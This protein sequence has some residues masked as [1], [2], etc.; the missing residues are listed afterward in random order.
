[1]LKN[2]CSLIQKCRDLTTDRSVTAVI[3]IQEDS[4]TRDEF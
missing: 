1:M 3:N 2:S 4:Y